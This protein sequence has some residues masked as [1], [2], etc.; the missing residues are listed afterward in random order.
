MKMLPMPTRLDWSDVC[1]IHL[2]PRGKS[3]IKTYDEKQDRHI[4]YRISRWVA[5]LAD[6]E[7]GHQVNALKT[8]LRDLLGAKKDV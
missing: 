4:Y 3:Y 5:Q 2:D 7:A 1:E 6:N 8:Q